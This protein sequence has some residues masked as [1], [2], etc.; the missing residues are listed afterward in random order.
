MTDEVEEIIRKLFRFHV[1]VRNSLACEVVT[2][3]R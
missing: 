2:S 3:V 1:E